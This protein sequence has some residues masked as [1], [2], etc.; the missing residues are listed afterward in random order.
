MSAFDMTGLRNM[1]YFLW[2]EILHSKKGIIVHQPKYE[3]ELPKR[4][5]SMNCKSTVTPIETNHK[6]DSDDDGED[7]RCC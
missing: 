2:M 1:I 6:L 7:V 3:L 4:F 5:K